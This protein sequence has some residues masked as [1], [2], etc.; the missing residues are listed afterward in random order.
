MLYKTYPNALDCGVSTEEFWS[1]TP[2][3]I[4]DRIESYQRKIKQEQIL[5]TEQLFVLAEAIGSRVAFIL[6][7]QKD[8]SILLQPWDVYPQ[9][10]A[11]EKYSAEHSAEDREFEAYK[12]SRRRHAAEFNRRREEAGL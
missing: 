7:D 8:R 2:V 12:E 6:S 11:E 9:L 1:M 3:E 10:F 4:V 5:K